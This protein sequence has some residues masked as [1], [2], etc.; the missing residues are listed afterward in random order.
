MHGLATKGGQANG[1]TTGAEP[2]RPLFR[3]FPALHEQVA[4]LPLGEFPTPV[5]QLPLGPQNVNLWIKRDDL[6]AYEY[7]GNKVRAL[8]FALARAQQRGK[9]T[10]VACGAEGSNWLLACAVHA[11]RLGLSCRLHTFRRC[12]DPARLLNARLVKHLASDVV[13]HRSLAG[14]LLSVLGERLRSV[15]SSCLLPAAGAS[16]V[17]SLGYVNAVL[18]LADQVDA[19]LLPRPSV[20]FAPLGS[21]GT[22]AGI[23]VGLEIVGWQTKLIGVRVVDRVVSNRVTV[24]MLA[25]GCYRLLR[26]CDSTL[27]AQARLLRSFQVAHSWIGKGYGQVTE[28]ARQAIEEFE[29]LDLQLDTTYT[30]KT[31]ACLLH[32]IRA[33]DC[34][35]QTVLYWHT[36][37]SRPLER[38]AM[39][40]Q[41]HVQQPIGG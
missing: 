11:R 38:L 35:D 21:G 14:L 13:H 37:N 9:P 4:W 32:H 18:E 27:P 3:R 36:L 34:R 24:A 15:G 22:C 5:E 30:G 25:R 40:V 29:R 7:G 17:C 10:V 28:A 8:E 19:G 1:F 12:V 33:G 39:L 26:R 31:V 2:R 6:T 23:L 20:M 16:P 41:E